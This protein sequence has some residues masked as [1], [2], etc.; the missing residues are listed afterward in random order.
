[1]N[2]IAEERKVNIPIDKAI[3]N[4]FNMIAFL[5]NTIRSNSHF[6]EFMARKSQQGRIFLMKSENFLHTLLMSMRF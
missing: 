6:V 3:E 5:A 2:S 4:N 1:M